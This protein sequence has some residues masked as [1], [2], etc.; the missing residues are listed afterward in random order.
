[1]KIKWLVLGCIEAVFLQVNS[2]ECSLESSWRDLHDLHSFAPLRPQQ[3]SKCSSRMLV[4]RSQFFKQRCQKF[5]IV[6]QMFVP[7]CA[8]T[9]PFFR[10]SEVTKFCQHFTDCPEFFPKLIPKIWRK[11][12]FFILYAKIISCSVRVYLIFKNALFQ[13]FF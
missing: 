7:I 4:I 11:F 6:L 2:T 10:K 3:F 13:N 12:L 9:W 8:A 1:M 5:S